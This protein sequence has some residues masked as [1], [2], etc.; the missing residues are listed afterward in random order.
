MA[1]RK[2]KYSEV[3]RD[4]TESQC[5]D[6]GDQKSTNL[7]QSQFRGLQ[8]IKK[9]VKEGSII[10]MPTDK[11]G[12]LAAASRGAYKEMGMKHVSKDRE[13]TWEEAGKTQ[14][15]LN[16]NCSMWIKMAGLGKHW[17]QVAR[18]RETM[19]N[20]STLVPPCTYSVRTT[21]QLSQG[22]F[23]AQDQLSVVVRA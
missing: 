2:A 17:D 11:T 3:T 13:I 19:I 22:T 21:R 5:K 4:F 9:R 14:R 16:G 12:G 18:M 8:S 1:A 10:I 6:S 20:H 7:T 15:I 23:P